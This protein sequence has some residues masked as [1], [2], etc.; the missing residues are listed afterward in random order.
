MNT[1]SSPEDTAADDLDRLAM[2]LAK[3]L[4]LSRETVQVLTILLERADHPE[5]LEKFFDT[6]GIGRVPDSELAK[7]ATRLEAEPAPHAQPPRRAKAGATGAGSDGEAT[8]DA[9]TIEA[10]SESGPEVSEA[11]ALE[12]EAPGPP[13]GTKAPSATLAGAVAGAKTPS[14]PAQ[15]SDTDQTR[16]SEIALRDPTKTPAVLRQT[17]EGGRAA[18]PAPQADG[19]PGYEDADRVAHEPESRAEA[20]SERLT[21]KQKRELE[22]R[23]REFAVAKLR[24]LGYEV[25]LLP[26]YHPGY[27]L[28]AA[29]GEELLHIEVKGHLGGAAVVDL[30]MREFQAYL[31]HAS[32]RTREK[33]QLWNC[34]NIAADSPHPVILTRYDAIPDEALNVRALRLDL[35]KCVPVDT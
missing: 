4:G 22:R 13:A 9:E 19:R 8:S 10:A 18:S 31:A 14:K 27:D 21:D 28:V 34:E 11:I 15:R 7:L 17:Y 26:Y 32:G 1:N 30:S 24:E 2:E 20:S 23:A 12:E 29:K 5:R 25:T 6:R 35:R 16:T 3:L 33:W